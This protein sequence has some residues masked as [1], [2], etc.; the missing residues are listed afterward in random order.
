ME[1][2]LIENLMDDLIELSL[3]VKDDIIKGITPKTVEE[4]RRIYILLSQAKEELLDLKDVTFSKKLSNK[5]MKL[6][7]IIETNQNLINH[8]LSFINR[9]IEKIKGEDLYSNVLIKIKTSNTS[10]V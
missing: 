3:K 2:K 7:N 4:I 1:D 6:K 10:K 5:I 8:Q 9:L